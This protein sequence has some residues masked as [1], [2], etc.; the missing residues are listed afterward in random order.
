MFSVSVSLSF[1]DTPCLSCVSRIYATWSASPALAFSASTP[2]ASLSDVSALPGSM[3]MRSGIKYGVVRFYEMTGLSH[4]LCIRP[5]C[6]CAGS[7]HAAQFRPLRVRR[8]PSSGPLSTSPCSGYCG[9]FV[10]TA[11]SLRSL[12]V[13]TVAINLWFLIHWPALRDI[14]MLAHLTNTKTVVSRYVLRISP[15]NT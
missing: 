11:G 6:R 7:L 13:F 2:P 12:Q 15:T 4:P 1:T 8:T 10:F 14:R 5:R 9:D 3:T